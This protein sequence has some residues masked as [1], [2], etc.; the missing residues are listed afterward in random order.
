[1]VFENITFK[2]TN[3]QVSEK[4][5]SL[6]SSKFEALGKYIEAGVPARAEVEFERVA[7]HKTGPICR[8]EANIWVD[9]KLYRAETTQE[10]FEA[11]VDVIKSELDQELRKANTK[12][13][14]LFRR[15]SRKIKE[16]MRFGS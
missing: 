13:T 7:S 6:V 14:S 1:M 2:H 8:M 10:T 12:R 5:H 9:G 3:S 11:A 15:G 4:I 16:M